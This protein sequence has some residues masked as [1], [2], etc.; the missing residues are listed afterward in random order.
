MAGLDVSGEIG[1]VAEDGS[2]GRAAVQLALVA[3][4]D[5]E[6]DLNG[7]FR[8]EHFLAQ[9]A[10]VQVVGVDVQQMFLQLVGFVERF[11][12]RLASVFRRRGH[13]VHGHVKFELIGFTDGEIG[14]TMRAAIARMSGQTNHVDL[15]RPFVAFEYSALRSGKRPLSTAAQISR[16]TLR[17]ADERVSIG[18]CRCG[19]CA[20]SELRLAVESQD[21]GQT[22]SR[23]RVLLQSRKTGEP[24]TAQLTGV[25]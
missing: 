12:T 2:A 1:F 24:Q 19:R 25:E 20:G 10:P 9:G 6:M 3:V 11:Q 15:F 8:V 7:N 14:R 16:N 18:R 13:Q 5:G 4:F 21:I 17:F 22:V 23:Q